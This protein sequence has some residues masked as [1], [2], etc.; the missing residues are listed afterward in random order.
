[1]QQ[2]IDTY[3][4]KGK[5]AIVRVDFNVPLDENFNITDD[6]RIRA[7]LPTLKKV[8]AEGGSLILMSHLGRRRELTLSSPSSIFSPTSPSA[9]EFR[10]S[11]PRT[12]RR[13]TNRLRPSSQV[14]S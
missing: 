12:A 8:L 7:A 10:C 6:T 5:K 1:M 2:H 4:F 11:S 14:R 3:D 9:S 13:L